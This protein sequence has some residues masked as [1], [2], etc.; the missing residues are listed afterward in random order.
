MVDKLPRSGNITPLVRAPITSDCKL[1][2]VEKTSRTLIRLTTCDS[3]RSL[4]EPAS[5]LAFTEF[6]LVIGAVKVVCGHQGERW[7]EMG[8]LES[9]FNTSNALAT[10]H[11]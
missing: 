8:G 4:L 6:R 10:S 7:H 1:V 11:L 2:L 5:M 3:F 9:C